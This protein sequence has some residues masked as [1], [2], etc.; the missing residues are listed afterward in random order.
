M[1]II[2]RIAFVSLPGVLAGCSLQGAQCYV[3]DDSRILNEAHFAGALTTEYCAQYC[4]DANFSLAGVENGGE[5]YC[6]HNVRAGAKR[7][8]ASDC[9]KPC[10]GDEHEH[11]G[12]FWRLSVF[13]FS[14]SGK[15]VPVPK[16]P[17]LLL[18]PCLNKTAPW[19]KQPWCDPTLPIDDRVAD[20]VSRMTLAEKI[21]SLD[22][23]AHAIDSLGLP[24]YNWWSEA[25]HGISHVVNDGNTPYESNFAFPITTAMSFNRTLWKATGQQIGREARA[26][27]NEGNAWSTYWAPVVNLAREP[28][29]GRNIETPGEDPY[30]SG[31]YAAAFVQGFEHSEDDPTHLQASA[32]CKHYVANSMEASTVAGQSFDRHNFD[33]NISQQDLVD[34]YMLP[35]Q[36]CVEKGK[37][38]SLMCSYN[39]VNGVPSCANKWLLQTVARDAW[40]FDGYITSDCGAVQD[41]YQNHKYAATPEEAVRDIMHAG[42]DVDCTSFAGKYGKSALDKGLITEAEIDARL[43]KLFRVR[44]RLSHFD[45]IGPLDKIPYSAVCDEAAIATARDGVAQGATLLKN[46]GKVLPLAPTLGKVAVIGPNA[47][48]SKAISSYYGGNSCG[49][50]GY[51]NL[52][53][54]VAAVVPGTVTTMGVPDVKSDDESDIPAAAAMAKDADAVVLAL[55]TDL[56]WGREGHDADSITFS[57]GQL[58]LIKAVTAAASKPVV[59]VTFTATPLDLTPLV[60]NTKVGAILHVGQPSVQVHGI[61]DVLFGRKSP[62]G[63]MVQTVYPKAY[64]DMISIF[65]FNM[66]PGPSAWPRPDCPASHPSSCPR[67]TNPGRTYRFY[68]G[69][70]VYEFGYGLSYTTFTYKVEAATAPAAVALEPL[71]KLLKTTR[72]K[73][74]T[75]FPSLDDVPRAATYQVTVTNTGS[76]DADDVVLGFLTP[77]GA[78]KDG[79]PLKVLFAFERVHV[80]AGQ[81]VTV[82]LY[83]ALTDFAFT[84]AAGERKPLAGA[85]TVHFGVEGTAPNMG[86]VKVPLVATLAGA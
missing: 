32:C 6:G 61:A 53:D 63:R 72:E 77:P 75:H 23:T 81:S 17:P 16:G 13:S 73:T 8:D 86:Y 5:C 55:G 45:P 35:F 15:P 52:A 12:G 49:N 19:A 28:R 24:A 30:L 25:T 14:C 46:V 68:T 62:A 3:D 7:A 85:Y 10:T 29:W 48:L 40:G 1:S 56:T 79:I 76:V 74:G 42:T 54:A 27:M 21:D 82:Y 22:T 34:S 59:V 65:D 33:A 80:K 31:E 69:T 71:V 37:V 67:G 20:M 44:M 36:A 57:D 4:H 83:P 38:S 64:G 18:N 60:N 2:A 78:G 84:T 58:A 43:H 9:N 47:N 41:V 66:R 51:P 39:E 50:V 26:F 70:P 11:C